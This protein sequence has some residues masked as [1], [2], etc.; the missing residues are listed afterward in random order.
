M[1]NPSKDKPESRKQGT[2][3]SAFG[4]AGRINHDASEFY[5]SKLYADQEPPEPETWIEN[6]IPT[7]SLDQ[8]YC[9]S[10]AGY[11]CN[12]RQ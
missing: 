4:T 7:E 12:P 8:L 5:G 3:T 9:A 1:G 10:S 11:V 6:P 2:Q